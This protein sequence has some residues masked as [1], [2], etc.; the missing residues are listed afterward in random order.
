MKASEISF[1]R[2]MIFAA[3]NRHLAEPT[4]FMQVEHGIKELE[5]CWQGF[6]DTSDRANLEFKNKSSVC[7][8]FAQL[9]TEYISYAEPSFDKLGFSALSDN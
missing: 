4:S 7:N 2:M 5:S 1:R 9:L 8:E 6:I 3:G